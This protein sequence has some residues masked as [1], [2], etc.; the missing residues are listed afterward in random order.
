MIREAA[1][2]GLIAIHLEVAEDN[3]DALYL[4]EKGGFQKVGRRPG[5]YRRSKDQFVDA[6]LMTKT[7]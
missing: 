5:Y 1:D 3:P 4:Y 2:A 6:I 7:L